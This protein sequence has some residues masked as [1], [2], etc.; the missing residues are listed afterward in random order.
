MTRS[1]ILSS[2]LVT[3]LVS[4]LLSGFGLSDK[5]VDFAKNCFKESL[6]LLGITVDKGNHDSDGL[7][8]V[9]NMDATAKSKCSGTE[10]LG[11]DPGHVPVTK[12]ID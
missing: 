8:G 6:V 9:L 10:K 12:R 5:F 7:I 11:D 3:T 1:L 2:N 4:S